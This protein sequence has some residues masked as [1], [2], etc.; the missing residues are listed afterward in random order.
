MAVSVAVEFNGIVF[1]RYPNAKRRA[2]Q[3]Y[4][5]PTPI[6]RERGVGRLHQEIW[7]AAH[8][9]IPDGWHVHHIDHDPLNN[10]LE[11]LEC[12]PG[13][14]HLAEHGHDRVVDLEHMARIR[15]LT[16]E[17]HGSEAGLEWHRQHGVESWIGR[18]MRTECCQQCGKTYE[19]RSA[20]GRERFCSNNCKSAWR[21]A[22]GVDDVDRICEGCGATFRVS[23]YLPTKNC[24]RKCA[25]TVRKRAS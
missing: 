7:K 12:K 9:L 17:W 23:R 6:H 21:R 11:N 2:D 19:T 4:Y 22:S 25:W 14:Q 15:P 24:S 13:A 1:R 10:A 3:V 20:H 5:T 16:V 18:E 8:G